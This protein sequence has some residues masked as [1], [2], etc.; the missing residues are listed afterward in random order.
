MSLFI[1]EKIN[2]IILSNLE[3]GC[4]PWRKPWNTPS[5]KPQ[6]FATKHV[7][8]GCNFFI[9]SIIGGTNPYFLTLK[10]ANDL[11]GS[12][13]AGA[14]AI[15]IIYWSLMHKKDK[16]TGEQLEEKFGF[17]K[18]SNVFKAD[19]IKGIEFPK[20]ELPTIEFSPN[21]AAEKLIKSAREANAIAVYN[22]EACGAYYSPSDDK[23]S[24]PKRDIF[25]SS[26]EFYSTLFHEAGHSTGHESRLNRKSLTTMSRF[27]SHEYSKEELVAELVAAYLCAKTG[28]NNTI[29][30]TS[31]YIESWSKKLKD[32]PKWF[33]EAA[34][35][36]QK[37]ASY[38]S[39][40][41]FKESLAA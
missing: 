20:I 38:I 22:E 13:K 21:E 36:A 37:A 11:G 3:K 7:Y 2:N 31:A 28:I 29:E 35:Q 33:I 9:T 5:I 24:M 32:N 25:H 16:S 27:G 8:Q 39:Q 4:I 34:G 23:I 14:K 15:P 19:D 30:N 12:I 17:L 6:N 18:Y 26:H 41:H 40:E 10:Q 1:Y